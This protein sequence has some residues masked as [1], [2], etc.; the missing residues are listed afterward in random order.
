MNFKNKKDKNLADIIGRRYISIAFTNYVIRIF[1]IAGVTETVGNLRSYA[2][3]SKIIAERLESN[4]GVDLMCLAAT[5]GRTDIVHVLLKRLNQ[6]NIGPEEL[7]DLNC[8]LHQACKLNNKV[9]VEM[10]LKAGATPWEKDD[11]G[12]S[13]MHHAAFNGSLQ[14][15]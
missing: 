15:S 8:S 14:A 3:K 6:D 2:H 4:R 12:F 10:L 13:A 9:M 5:Y 11:D 1:L 7:F